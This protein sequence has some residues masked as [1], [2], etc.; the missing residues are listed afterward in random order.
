MKDYLAIA[1]SINESPEDNEYYVEKAIVL[2][3]RI[4]PNLEGKTQSSVKILLKKI[5]AFDER[6][7]NGTLTDAD[8]LQD[9]TDEIQRILKGG[10]IYF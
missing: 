10:K 9:F 3:E 6:V 1:I 5:I 4:I 2:L 8:N 7:A